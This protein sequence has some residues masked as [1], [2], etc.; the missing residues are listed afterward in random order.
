MDDELLK[1]TKISMDDGHDESTFEQTGSPLRR[2]SITALLDPL[3]NLVILKI[4]TRWKHVVS[5]NASASYGPRGKIVFVSAVN[6][7]KFSTIAK[8][9]IKRRG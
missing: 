3:T 8:L 2:W 1:F 4:K 9:Q 7:S 5:T 6:W